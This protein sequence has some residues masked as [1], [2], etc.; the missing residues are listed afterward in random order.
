[1]TAV[2]TT[3]L[4]DT[5]LDAAGDLLATEGPDALTVRRIADRAG[6]STMGV[7]THFG[8]K[9]GVVE[10]LFIEGFTRLQQAMASAPSTDDPLADLRASC[11]AYRTFALANPTHYLVMFERPVAGFVPSPACAEIALGTLAMLE[12]RVQRCL[13]AGAI[14]RAKGDASSLAHAVW[15]TGHGL[16]SLELH[17]VGHDDSDSERL[18]LVATDIVFA[19]LTH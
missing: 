13:D 10:A 17:H 5:L 4:R 2:A 18:Y 15:A 3:D 11:R 6:C 8:G 14:D 7:Y 12:Q 9:E 19:G 1:V 16:V